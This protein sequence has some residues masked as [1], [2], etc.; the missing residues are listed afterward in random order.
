LP[1]IEGLKGRIIETQKNGYVMV[2]IAEEDRPMMKPF[3]TRYFGKAQG[4]ADAENRPRRV[5]DLPVLTF[6]MAFWYRKRSLDQNAL[7]WAIMTILGFEVFQEFGHEEELHEEILA[8]YAPRVDGPLTKRPVPKRSKHLNTVE[9]SRL[10]EGV[11]KELAEHGVEETGSQ[12]IG[13][14]HDWNALREKEDP[15]EGSYRDAE[16]YRERIPYCEA[17]LK[18]LGGEDR[19]SIAHIISRGAGG[20]DADWNYLH[21]CDTCH[22]GISSDGDTAQHMHGWDAFLTTYPHLRWKWEKANGEHSQKEGAGTVPVSPP[23]SVSVPVLRHESSDR[24]VE[25]LWAEGG[26]GVPESGQTDRPGTG[27]DPSPVEAVK[28]VFGGEVVPD[29]LEI[30]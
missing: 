11:F 12:I 29:E 18:Y 22:T 20:P 30:F 13:F 9:F 15:L 23:D 28:A 10:I 25:S 5:G 3:L 2:Q 19:G 26:T 16:E 24:G 4:K 1:G 6:N 17:C 7:Y 8:I 21:L 27:T 14:Y